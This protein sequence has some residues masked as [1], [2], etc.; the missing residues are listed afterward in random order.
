M[1]SKGILEAVKSFTAGESLVEL[2]AHV[3]WCLDTGG[4]SRK[5]ILDSSKLSSLEVEISLPKAS[6]MGV[7][8]SVY[9]KLLYT[10]SST[11]VKTEKREATDDNDE[12]DEDEEEEEEGPG[13]STGLRLHKLRIPTFIGVNPNERLAKQMLVTSVE[14]D[15]YSHFDDHYVQLEE[16]VVKVPPPISSVPLAG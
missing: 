16:L 8:V 11:G 3:V 15:C 4:K 10:P 7:G 1:L 2:V 13:F 14:I 6:L 12:D 9:T 5:A